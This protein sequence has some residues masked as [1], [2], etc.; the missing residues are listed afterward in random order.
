MRCQCLPMSSVS[1]DMLGPSW[2]IRIFYVKCSCS[3][4]WA[5]AKVQASTET[6]ALP[7]NEDTSFA[8]GVTA[9]TN[10]KV[11]RSQK[12]RECCTLCDRTWQ[13]FDS[14]EA[15]VWAGSGFPS[16]VPM[17]VMCSALAKML[18]QD[19][20]ADHQENECL[21]T[22]SHHADG[23]GGQATDNAD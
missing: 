21:L 11:A 4:R 3:H 7:H 20:G 2:P 9:A 6:R 18:L 22:G 16:S 23:N 15:S 14:R 5:K 19:Q 12:K 10:G 1:K 13:W 17:Q 8:K